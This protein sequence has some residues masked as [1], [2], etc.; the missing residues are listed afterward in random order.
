VGMDDQQRG[1]GRVRP[2]GDPTTKY[3]DEVTCVPPDRLAPLVLAVAIL[4]GAAVPAGAFL[5]VRGPG[6]LRV[7]NTAE[8]P[9]LTRPPLLTLPGV[10][11]PVSARPTTSSASGAVLP[12]LGGLGRASAVSGLAPASPG[13]A[14]SAAAPVGGPRP[15]S[16]PGSPSAVSAAQSPAPGLPAPGSPSGVP[17]GGSSTSPPTGSSSTSPATVH[18]P[19]PPAGPTSSSPIT[20]LGL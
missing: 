12:R 13:R 9:R 19:V 7:K 3:A 16:T 15:V 18:G 5:I 11:G 10:T 14:P 17:A 4:V 1:R 6:D 8:A 2:P 20:V